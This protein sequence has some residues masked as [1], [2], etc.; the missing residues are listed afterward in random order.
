MEITI[1]VDRTDNFEMAI[2][3]AHMI[4]NDTRNTKRYAFTV[5]G[6]DQLDIHVQIHDSKDALCDIINAISDAKEV[7]HETRGAEERTVE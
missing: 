6:N 1:S 5:L 7:D 2:K 4:L 3:L